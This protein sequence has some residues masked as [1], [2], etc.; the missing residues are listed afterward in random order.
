M[1]CKPMIWLL[2]YFLLI[3]AALGLVAA[4][5]VR[6]DPFF[7]YHKPLTDEY[8]YT[9][10]NQRSQNDGIVKHF[11]YTGLITGTSM[12]ENFKASQAE[13]LWGGTFIKVCFS[14]S[15]YKE[16]NDMLAVALRHN[17]R[18]RVIV[19]GLDMGMI[20]NDKD[21]MR[22]DLGQ[23]PTYLYDDNV[24]N[25]VQY[26]FNR[27]VVFSRVYPMTKAAGEPDF[28]SGITSFDQYS[29]WM[30]GA[31][32]GKDR[33][34]PEGIP[35]MEA[36]DPVHLSDREAER[37]RSNIEQNVTGLA[38]EYPDVSF[39]YFFTPHS[40]AWWMKQVQDGTVYRQIEAERLAIEMILSCPNI[41]LYSFNCHDEITTDLNYYKDPGHYG[42]WVNALVLR[43]MY[44]GQDLLTA[45]NYQA[46]L[47]KELQ[48]YTSYDYSQLNDQ[49]DYEDD[50]LAASLLAADGLSA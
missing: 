19:R 44:D 7:H 3:G 1:R 50:S 23:Y 24:F 30:K 14:G 35:P 37:A 15:S 38:E 42:E 22:F 11:D 13:F 40:A 10:D 31:R 25:D 4:K 2:G 27:D 18:L 36:G 17:P 29:N 5:T 26:I 9:L 32:F 28:A 20:T 12:T 8:F 48:F 39:Y 16:I 6:V 46:Y 21:N 43:R 41:R 47:E 45:D 34:F 49:P 33:L